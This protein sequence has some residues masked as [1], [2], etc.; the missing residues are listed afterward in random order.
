[1]QLSTF[2]FVRGRNLAGKRRRRTTCRGNDVAPA[3]VGASPPAQQ[4]I[5]KPTL[6]EDKRAPLTSVLRLLQ[7]KAANK[8][9]RGR[10]RWLLLSV[11]AFVFFQIAQTFRMTL[12]TSFSNDGR[13]WRR[14]RRQDPMS[15]HNPPFPYNNG[16]DAAFEV[17]MYASDAITYFSSPAASAQQPWKETVTTLR[18]GSIRSNDHRFRV[19]FDVS[20]PGSSSFQPLLTIDEPGHTP[21]N[22]GFSE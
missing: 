5:Q 6:L 10:S 13:K 2:E 16:Q 22:R 15:F 11:C 3:V 12:W 8:Y 9:Q 19:I 4:S 18:R 20:F 17:S 21:D 1:M 14:Q 7:L